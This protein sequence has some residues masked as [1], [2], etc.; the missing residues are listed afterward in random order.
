MRAGNNSVSKSTKVLEDPI[1]YAR[2]AVRKVEAV[3]L[4]AESV[5]F[6]CRPPVSAGAAS[7]PSRPHPNIHLRFPPVC[8]KTPSAEASVSA[9]RSAAG[10]SSKASVH[11]ASLTRTDCS[12]ASGNNRAA[13]STIP[14]RRLRRP[15][16]KQNCQRR[17]ARREQ[18]MS[19]REPC[20]EWR[21]CWCREKCAKTRTAPRRGNFRDLDDLRR[22]P[23]S[24]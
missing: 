9:V 15:A 8:P 17:E 23:L 5:G 2:I 10:V 13:V 12:R 21:I 14:L 20:G 11:L 4:N 22:E 7:L 1:A 6:A 3:A 16:K 19:F 24:R 18:A